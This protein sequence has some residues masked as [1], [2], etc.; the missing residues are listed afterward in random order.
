MTRTIATCVYPVL[1]LAFAAVL[2]FI[3]A[4]PAMG[5]PTSNADSTTAEV[6]TSVSD[7]DSGPTTYNPVI[8]QPHPDFL[9]PNI[10]SKKP[11]RL[12]DYRGKKILLVHFASW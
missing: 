6:A 9:L 7:G 8:G 1:K 10:D 5:Q 11:T 4:S 2:S 12:S 3:I